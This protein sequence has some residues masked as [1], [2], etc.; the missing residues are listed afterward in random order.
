MGPFGV[1]SQGIRAAS[2]FAKNTYNAIGSKKKSR[3]NEEKV[4]KTTEEKITTTEDL[5]SEIAADLQTDKNGSY[6]STM[7]KQAIRDIS[8]EQ[9]SKR[10]NAVLTLADI[11]AKVGVNPVLRPL[12]NLLKDS[13]GNIRSKACEVLVDLKAKNAVEQIVSL[14][15][16]ESPRV[17]LESLRGIYKLSTNSAM[18]LSRLINATTE[19]HREIR[20]RAATYLGWTESEEAVEPLVNLLGDKEIIVRKNCSSSTW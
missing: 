14:L 16:D 19:Q 15:D 12:L 3:R 13:N 8:D 10:Y 17:R 4:E 9:P 5:L 11:G 1:T 2:G 7:L 6:E 20:K 18:V